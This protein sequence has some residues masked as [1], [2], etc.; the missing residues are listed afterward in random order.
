[1]LAQYKAGLDE[2]HQD[3]NNMGPIVERKHQAESEL[4]NATKL[5]SKLSVSG[6]AASLPFAEWLL[7]T[8]P[9][10]RCSRPL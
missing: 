4:K 10:R 9:R 8:L 1:M 5:A 7:T 3:S 6:S 2:H